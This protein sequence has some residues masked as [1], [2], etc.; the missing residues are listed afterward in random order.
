MS[1][2][3]IGNLMCL[4]FDEIEP[5]ESTEAPAYLIQASAKL[6]GSEGRNWIP[7]VVKEIEQDQY[8]VIGNIFVYAVAAE[9]GVKE[10]WC[11]IA[12]DSEE[13]QTISRALAGEIV[14]RTNLS[15]ASRE[16]ISAA[17]DY[18]IRQPNSPLKSVNLAT[19]V[20]RI[21]ESPRQYW[22]TLQPITKLGCRITA[23]KKLKALE[24]IFYLTPEPIPDVIRDRSLLE[25]FNTTQLKELAKKNKLQG[26]SK[27]NKS[28]LIDMLI[29]T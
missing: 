8:L 23:G 7:L 13:T 1:F 26:Y 25:S 14:P 6:L 18:L 17:L 2:S 27:M 28:K 22:V 5:G 21:D 10:V 16:E 24:D 12:D 9:A 11:I 4:P 15:I 19:A 20:A 3:D 29:A